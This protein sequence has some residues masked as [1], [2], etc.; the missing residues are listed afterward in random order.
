MTSRLALRPLGKW[1]VVVRRYGASPTGARFW[2]KKGPA[3]PLG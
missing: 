1:T 2:K 3:A